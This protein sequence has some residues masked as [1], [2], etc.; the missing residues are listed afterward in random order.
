MLRRVLDSTSFANR[1]FEQIIIATVNSMKHAEAQK[2]ARV[3]YIFLKKTDLCLRL[4]EVLRLLLSS[5]VRRTVSRYS[6]GKKDFRAVRIYL[7][8]QAE[9]FDQSHVLGLAS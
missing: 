3:H 6:V 4:N 8:C 5:T 9:D 7:N 2:K 1:G